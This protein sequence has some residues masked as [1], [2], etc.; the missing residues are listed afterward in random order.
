MKEVILSEKQWFRKT[1]W[2][3][4][5]ILVWLFMVSLSIFGLYSQIVLDIPFGTNPVSNEGLMVVT[6][7][8]VLIPT[9]LLILFFIG[10]LEIMITDE[11]LFYR[12]IPFI[13]KYRQIKAIDIQFSEARKYKPIREFGGWGIRYSLKHKVNCYNV[14]GNLGLYLELK[15]GK[16]LLLGSQNPHELKS[17]LDKIT[18]IGK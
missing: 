3:Y 2:L 7:F 12:Y 13:N 5:I 11:G 4:V 16:K 6:F 9:L 10:R 18:G 1:A 8:S 14:R 15:S 17:A